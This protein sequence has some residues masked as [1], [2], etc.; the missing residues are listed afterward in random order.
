[1]SLLTSSS[2]QEIGIAVTTGTPSGGATAVEVEFSE[3]IVVGTM[4][5]VV[6]T[7]EPEASSA[8][9]EADGL[10]PPAASE[11]LAASEVDSPALLAL[12]VASASA[13]ELTES[14]LELAAETSMVVV[15]SR[16]LV[17]EV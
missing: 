11:L 15:D 17:V 3:E 13:V 1:M 2:L 5:A 12:E 8:S 14:V 7:G 6:T 10:L 16:T 4:G 9:L